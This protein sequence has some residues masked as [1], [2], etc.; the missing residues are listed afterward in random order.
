MS[1][2]NYLSGYLYFAF[3]IFVLVIYSFI[4]KFVYELNKN[5]MSMFFTYVLLLF[6][7]HTTVDL[8]II[9]NLFISLIF[10]FLFVDQY[11][12]L[13]ITNMYIKKTN[14][15]ILSNKYLENKINI[16]KKYIVFS[17]NEYI[18]KMLNSFFIAMEPM[19]TYMHLKIKKRFT[20]IYM[21]FIFNNNDDNDD[22]DDSDSDNDNSNNLFMNS[23]M[24]NLLLSHNNTKKIPNISYAL[25]TSNKKF[26][27]NENDINRINDEIDIIT[28]NLNNNTF[29]VPNNE[30]LIIDDS[31]NSS[32]SS[33]EECS[34]YL[35]DAI[36]NVKSLSSSNS[37]LTSDDTLNNAN[38]SDNIININTVDDT[39]DKI[40]N[41]SN[42][43]SNIKNNFIANIKKEETFE[44]FLIE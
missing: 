18:K 21:N 40:N 23:N 32:N 33:S 8:K 5:N 39:H 17:N 42:N 37:D 25:N 41:K 10:I 36:S 29:L 35:S 19:H 12:C 28:N 9:I 4:M 31:S 38:S 16:V 44:D 11:M 24:L 7:F 27:Y 34:D 6:I 22:D 26:K 20:E 30:H 3:N 43:K 14:K 2:I 15:Y 1:I 13:K